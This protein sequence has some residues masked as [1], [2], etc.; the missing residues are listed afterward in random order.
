MPLPPYV[1]TSDAPWDARRVH[2]L[3]RRLGIGATPAQVT[4]ALADGPQATVRQVLAQARDEPAPPPPPWA[5][6]TDDDYDG[7]LELK[8]EHH[9]GLRSSWLRRIAEGS[10]RAKWAL[11]WHNHFV[12]QYEVYFCTA[13][14]WDYY[15]T[16]DRF[17]LGSFRPFVE[18]IG[19]SAAM[20]Y[21]LNGRDSVA[22]EPNENYA[23]ELMELFTMGRDNGYTQTDVVEVSRAL[24]GWR[25]DP[26]Y[27]C[28][29]R[30]YF[31][32]S[33][34]DDTPK[35]IFGQTGDFGYTE[36]HDLIFGLRQNQVAE[37]ICGK[38]YGHL[39]YAEP[40]EAVVAELARTFIA[41]GFEIAPVLAELAGS[42]HF[43][44][45][46]FVGARI[47]PPLE[48]FAHVLGA[49]EI[50]GTLL[51]EEALDN[52]VYY[53]LLLGQDLLDPVDVAGWPGH[54]AWLNENTLATRWEL[55]SRW[56]AQR[57][58]G[59]ADVRTHLRDRAIAISGTTTDYEV[60]VDAL[61]AHWLN[62][63][64]TAVQREG[65]LRNFRGEI[66]GNYFDDGTWNMYFGEAA[67]Q[68]VNLLLYLIRQPEWQLC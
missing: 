38:L 32:A 61:V 22:G 8:S 25:S 7:D 68:V 41:G 59:D 65:A 48:L 33:R 39:C 66:P 42:A 35:T 50:G 9:G 23:R 12:T 44:E 28:E 20:L 51:Q 56:I 67:D 43:F 14:A 6:W 46:R 31:D 4:R 11:F 1:P 16:L 47:K 24:T 54:H 26:D 15:A 49:L 2:H 34:F 10:V 3:Y 5:N 18:A 37:Y 53:S 17:A 36:V 64:I 29:N 19:T 58:A 30:V 52:A 62:A 45:E 63:P 57:L 60:V 13:L 27:I 55:L 21:Y 40:D